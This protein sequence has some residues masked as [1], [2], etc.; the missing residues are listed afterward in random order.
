VEVNEK[1]DKLAKQGTTLPQPQLHITIT[2]IGKILYTMSHTT[3]YLEQV[4]SE[5]SWECLVKKPI[6]R[7][8]SRPVKMAAFRAQIGHD[9]LAAHLHKI[10]IAPSPK[11]PLCSH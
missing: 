10:E 6:P 2:L 3:S 4:S 5:N 11:C 1:A 7:D 9:Y 8:L